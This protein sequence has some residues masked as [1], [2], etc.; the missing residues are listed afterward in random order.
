[1]SLTVLTD[2]KAIRLQQPQQLVMALAH[3]KADAILQRL[4]QQ[5][6]QQQPS[7]SFPAAAASSGGEPSRPSNT[8]L[9][10]CD[11]VVVHDGQIREK[12]EDAQEAHRWV[13]LTLCVWGG[14][15]GG[16]AICAA[17]DMERTESSVTACNM[18][19]IGLQHFI[20][21]VMCVTVLVG[22]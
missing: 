12:P 6:Q 7:G 13:L 19:D 21:G 1:M 8:F 4:Q 20:Q 11:Q 15:R 10:T 3:A 14:G 9:I 2:E 5:Q 22:Q 18:T 16:A 17:E